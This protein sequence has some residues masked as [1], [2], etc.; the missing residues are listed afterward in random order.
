MIN[1]RLIGIKSLHLLVLAIWVISCSKTKVSEQRIPYT[2]FDDF[3]TG[4]LFGWEQYP[5]AEDIGFDALFSTHKSPTF[6]NS[7]YALARPV[8]ANDIVEIYQGFTKRID[9]WTTP[10]TRLKTALYFQSDR[11]PESLEISLGTFDGRL[12]KHTLKNPVANQW[13][14]LDI[15]LSEFQSDEGQLTANEHIQVVTIEGTYPKVYYLFTYTILMDNFQL[16]GERQRKFEGIVPSSTHFDMFN[17]ST[18]NKHYYL[19]DTIAMAVQ[20]EGK[21]TLK[22][23][24]AKLIDGDGIIINDSIPFSYENGSW[25]NNTI[26]QVSNN[27]AR[28]QWEILFEGKPEV[29]P[30]VSSGFKFLVPVKP[31]T[32]HPRLF[33]SKTSLRDRLE[34]ENSPIAKKILENAVEDTDFMD[35]D[36]EAIE[37]GAD[38]TAE[39]L[40]GGP[41]SKTTVGFK[42]YATWNNP[43]RQLGTIIEKGSFRYAFTGDMKAAEKAKKALLK[44]CSFKKWNADWMLERKFWTYYP[45]GYTLLPIA[46]GYDILYD[47]LSEQ[48]RKFVREAIMEK[49]IKHFH[50]DM[51]EMNRMSSNLT[52]HIAVLVGGHGLAA[53]AIYGDDPDNPYLEPYLSGIITKAQ[54]FIEN[55]YYEDGSYGEPKSGYMNMATKEIVLIMEAFER[56]F[57]LN[58]AETTDV[59]SF[60]KYP[61]QASHPNGT[62]PDFGDG[63][64][65]FHSFTQHHS[66]YFVYRTGN[67]FLY[68]YVKPHW[69]SGEGGYWGYLWY[70][71]DV[72]PKSREVFPSSK[73]FEAQGI[74]MRSDWS[75]AGSV[76]SA[77]I[78]PHSNHY[79]FDQ[80]SFQIF[81][82]GEPLLTDPSYGAVPIW[83]LLF[84]IFMPLLTMYS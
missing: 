26:H 31:V 1:K 51:V 61:L 77:R 13:L 62:M 69:D 9:M 16:N 2:L 73:V 20:P 14:E 43:N 74:V 47:L 33:F 75:D 41:Y 45:V 46:Y 83:T 28:G 3:E 18:L 79:H 63:G 22:S 27:S 11:N 57:G 34:N 50:R 19:N 71:D 68:K 52:N 6:N 65:Y 8:R 78:G 29:G 58:W 55:T 17:V 10:D 76:I 25:V 44:L 12:F 66:E 35:I 38:R 56:N 21:I 84:I 81:T 15:S 67:P 80:G 49:G 70:R 82:N 4:E 32:E 23:L 59:E 39:N 53:T 30:N 54:A 36:I 64:S 42:A 40:V 37:E 72:V 5:Y 24:W 60:Y 7:N 48:E